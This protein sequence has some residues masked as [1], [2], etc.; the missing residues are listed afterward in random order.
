[1]IHDEL[2]ARA[3][4]E[5]IGAG[6]LTCAAVVPPGAQARATVSAKQAGVLAGVE[7]AARVFVTVDPGVEVRAVRGDAEAVAPG[8]VVLELAGP[9]AS[10]LSAERVALNFLGRLSGVATA[11]RALVDSVEGTGARILDTR[12]TTPGLRVLEKAAVVAGGGVSHRAGLYD[13][14]LIKENHVRVAGGVAEAARRGLAG[15]PDGVWVEIEVESLAEL[16]EALAAGVDRILLDNM[17]PAQMAEA[18]GRAG[19]Q[20]T[21]EA[22]GGIGHESIRAVAESGVDYISVG[23]LTHSAPALDVSLLFDPS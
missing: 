4:A 5:D 22:S 11:T 23:A 21:L 7:V 9:A 10:I 1:L 14:I 16:D 15:A 8:D 2:I 3:L 18:V 20:A 6:D 12:K 13:A 19:G 17:S